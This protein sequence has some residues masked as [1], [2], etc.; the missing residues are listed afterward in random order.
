MIRDLSTKAASDG[1]GDELERF[2]RGE[3]LRLAD[4]REMYKERIQ[5][6]WRRQIAALSVD[7]GNEVARSDSVIGSA[8][9]SGEVDGGSDGGGDK[10]DDSD[11]SDD[12]DDDFAAMMEMEMTS[13]GEANR[14]VAAQLRG[15]DD[16]DEHMRAIG[17]SLD[18]QELSKDARELAALQR[19]REEER[20]MQEGLDIKKGSA[21]GLLPKK[22][23]KCIRRRVTKVCFSLLL[24]CFFTVPL[25][26]FFRSSFNSNSFFL[27]TL[28]VSLYV[29]I[30][31]TLSNMTDSP[32]RDSNCY[33]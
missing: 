21:M 7:A 29:Q 23:G 14:L 26:P 15:D 4:Q 33:F 22:R 1:M 18:T 3:K 2:A 13:T 9:D 27:L 24:C 5:E 11:D 32:R 30:V 17:R 25:F 20:A 31:S 10:G 16:G 8:K 12:D 19:Q 28:F 6:I